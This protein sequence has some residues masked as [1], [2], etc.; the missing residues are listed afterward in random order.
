VGG[1]PHLAE[2]VAAVPTSAHVERYAQVVRERAT[3][4][5]LISVATELVR[6]GFD[7]AADAS[8]LLER[9]EQMIF[10]LS[11][12]RAGDISD[13][14]D[15]IRDVFKRLEESH[16]KNVTCTGIP[17]GYGDLDELTSGLQRGELIIIAGRP[18]TGKTSFALNVIVH[19]A[20]ELAIPVGV[21]SL[22]MTKE[23][24]AQNMACL[25]ARVDSHQLRK[26]MLSQEDWGRLINDGMSRLSEAP[27]FIDDSP[28]DK[29][30][31]QLRARA[32]RMLSRQKVGL[33]VFDYLQLVSGPKEVAA[34]SRQQEVAY[35]SRSLKALAQELRI[36]VVALCQLNRG[37]E[38]RTNKRP[39][40]SDLRES[41]AIEQDADLVMMIHRPGLYQDP[42]ALDEP[43]QLLVS[44]NRNGPV[45]DIRLTFLYRCFRFESYIPEGLA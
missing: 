32:R 23:Q 20:C 40:L 35:I 31:V 12:E 30:I 39:Q 42:P 33:L 2:L 25:C 11:S 21:F 26:G 6:T 22:E 28:G 7:P 8:D 9:A 3:L 18:S 41:G 34:Q 13:I 43:T 44:K 17:T 1:N 27:I 15:I 5:R 19:A 14:K 36:P 29:G 4:R 45:G 10:S 37:L 24:L 16:G 38:E